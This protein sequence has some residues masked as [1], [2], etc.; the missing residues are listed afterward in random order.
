MI[1]IG[2]IGAGTAGT[3]L[4]VKLFQKGC[5]IVA[6]SSRSISSAERLARFIPGC[7]VYSMAQEVA[8][9]ADL[10][11]ITTPDDIIAK[12]S[13]EIQ[14][15]SGQ[16]VL[17]CSGAHSIDILEAANRC[18]A[19]VG[20]FH[21][22]QTFASINQAMDNLPGSTFAIEAEEPLLSELKEFASL[23]NGRS[24]E[25]KSGEKVLYHAAAVFV[26]NYLVTLVKLSLDLWKAF[27]V[28]AEEATHALL[29]L[30]RGTVNNIENIGLPNC[31]TGPISRGDL[32]TVEKHLNALEVLDSSICNIYGELGLQTIPIALDKGKIERGKAE[33][34]KTLLIQYEK[35]LL[36]TQ[37]KGKANPL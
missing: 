33:E 15:H 6:V 37:E 7:K 21:P 35:L 10:V 36:S 17:H 31:L 23:L 25:L 11:F 5:S 29:P 18:G 3:A 14:W 28:S 22:L 1:R 13:N 8:D 32:G 30:L 27:G 4:A 26:S 16:G 24:V 19:N 20:S 12:V 9:L 2:F 34:L